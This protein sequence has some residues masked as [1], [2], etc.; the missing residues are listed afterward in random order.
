MRLKEHL[1]KKYDSK[2]KMDEFLKSYEEFKLGVMLKEERKK[3]KMTQAMIASIMGTHKEAI[4]RL[5]NHSENMNVDTLLK[6]AAALGMK[7]KIELEK[8][9]A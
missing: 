3:A 4:S 1:K 8:V 2:E 7:V 6:Y 9:E 5:E